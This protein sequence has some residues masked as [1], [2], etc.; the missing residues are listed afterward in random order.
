MRKCPI[1]I[2]FLNHGV[3]V[4]ADA[5]NN[6]RNMSTKSS[7]SQASRYDWYSCIGQLHSREN[8]TNDDQQCWKIIHS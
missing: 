3:D 5:D 6:D 2:I 7:N 1:I 4:G 8:L